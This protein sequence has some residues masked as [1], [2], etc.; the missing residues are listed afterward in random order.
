MDEWTD[1][2]D[3]KYFENPDDTG[4]LSVSC[5]GEAALKK[6]NIP[7][8]SSVLNLYVSVHPFILCPFVN[9]SLFGINAENK[10]KAQQRY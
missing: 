8:C 6:N 4:P 1:R 3:E 9:Y 10:N 5:S 2:R 7:K